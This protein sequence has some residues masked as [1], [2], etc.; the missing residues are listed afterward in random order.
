MAKDTDNSISFGMGLLVGVVAGVIAGVLYSPKPGEE[1][2]K[3]LK[4]TA[5]RL[6]GT[7]PPEVA[8]AKEA[9]IQMIDKI[10]CQVE[11]QIQKINEAL[12]AGRMAAA[13]QRE[14]AESGIEY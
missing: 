5:D 6:S 13:K 7:V 9:G 1:L 10:K 14:E 2:R 11:I 12:K 4:D 3:E 8:A